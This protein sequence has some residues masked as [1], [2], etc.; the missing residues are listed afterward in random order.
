MLFTGIIQLEN[1]TEP[2]QIHIKLPDVSVFSKILF[3]IQGMTLLTM[4]HHHWPLFCKF[5]LMREAR[6]F[7][8]DKA[9]K[10]GWGIAESE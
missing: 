4:D 8:L 3:I 1:G 6:K 9:E 7:Y 10:M 2:H 5:Y